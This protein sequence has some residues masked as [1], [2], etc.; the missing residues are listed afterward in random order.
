MYTD[1]LQGPR[2]VGD[3]VADAEH[4]D[5]N[6]VADGIADDEQARLADEPGPVLAGAIL[7]ETARAW[8]AEAGTCPR[9]GEVGPYHDREIA[10]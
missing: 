3:V 6:D 2:D 10:G 9:C 8:W 7:R 4:G 1:P 5:L